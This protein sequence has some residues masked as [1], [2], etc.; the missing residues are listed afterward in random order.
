MRVLI[1]LLICTLTGA[2]GGPSAGPDEQLRQWV[3]D[4]EAHAENKERRALMDMISAAY[5]DARGNDIESV[6]NMLRLYFL[7]MQNISLL[8]TI[9]E[10][11][12]NAD[13]AAEI[14]LTVA[15]LGTR[16]SALGL[17]ADA[18]RFHLEL[19]HDG[20][21]WLLI[22]ARYGELGGDMH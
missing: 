5:A 18:Y 6:E 7:R 19:E 12:V 16:D 3:A 15:M 22:G 8:S 10:L 9:D 4:A 21:E 11:I 17:D 14:E 2:C 1:L 20:D 13:S